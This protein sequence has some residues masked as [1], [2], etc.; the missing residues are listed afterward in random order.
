MK[1]PYIT[2]AGKIVVLK[3]VKDGNL[4]RFLPTT[5]LVW[6]NVPFGEK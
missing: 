5:V 2:L 6:K 4:I 1:F 3:R